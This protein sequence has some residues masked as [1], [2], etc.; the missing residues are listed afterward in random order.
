MSAVGARHFNVAPN[1]EA[2]AVDFVPGTDI[3]RA[4]I[5]GAVGSVQPCDAMFVGNLEIGDFVT[6]FADGEGAFE[7]EVDAVEG[8]NILIG[9]HPIWGTPWGQHDSQP[10]AGV[11][12]YLPVQKAADGV[13]LSSAMRIFALDNYAW[14]IRGTLGGDGLMPG[15]Q[16]PI[17]GRVI[18]TLPSDAKPPPAT[19]GFGVFLIGDSEGRQVG[20]GEDFASSFLTPTGL[21]IETGFRNFI[22][23]SILGDVPIDWG[24][25]DGHWVADF[26]ATLE[27]PDNYRGGLYELM[28]QLDIPLEVPYV[29][30]DFLHPDNCCAA[31]LGNFTIGDPAPMRVAATLLADVFSEGTRGG[32]RARE[33]AMTFDISPR[34]ATRHD[35]VVPRLDS[36]GELWTYRLEPYVPLFGTA[37]R[38]SPPVPP[39]ALDFSDSEL[40]VTIARP[41]GQTQ[42]LGP[43][44]LTRYVFLTPR[45]PGC[46]L[47]KITSGS[48]PSGMPQLQGR[49]DTFAYQFPLYG[50]YVVTLEGHIA[51]HT[52][53]LYEIGGTYDITV[54]NVLDIETAMLPG[55]PFE[56][57][58]AIA[59]TLTVMPGVPAEVSYE[60]T[61]VAADGET[62]VSVFT[63]RANENGWWDGDGDVFAFARHGEYRIDV[64]AR[65]TDGKGDLWAGRLRFGSA[66]ATPDA[67][68]IAHGRR[69]SDSF[70]V[71][72]PPWFFRRDFVPSDEGHLWPPFFTGDIQWGVTE[73]R[74]DAAISLR[75]SVQIVDND[76]PL[77][78]RA[79]ELGSFETA[80]GVTAVVTIEESVRAGS[81]ALVMRHDWDKGQGMHPEE[82]E[83]WSYMYGSAQRPGVR[84]REL[85]AGEDTEDPYWFFHD[86]YLLQSGNGQL[87]DEPGDFKFQYAAAVIRDD[88][89]GE[90][91]YAIYG[92]G[93]VLTSEDDTLGARVM[94]PFQGAAGGPSGGPLFTVHGREVDMFFLPLGVR[95]GAVLETGDVFRMAGPIMPTLPSRIGY[96]VIA[97]DGKTR[98]FD[99]RANAVGYFYDPADDFVLDQPGLWTV[100]LTV[101]HDGLTSAGPVEPP[102]PTGGPLTPDG[103]AFTF[104]VM[105]GDT[106]RLSVDTDSAQSTLDQW[107]CGGEPV[108]EAYFEAA[109]P[110][111][112]TGDTARVIV[113]MPG[114]VLVDEDAVVRA[115]KIKWDLDARAL[116]RLA[117]NFDYEG[118]TGIA[119]TITVTFFAEGTLNGQSAQAAG[120]IVTHGARV[121]LAPAAAP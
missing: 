93:W 62:T 56:V 89:S 102:F 119:D 37:E 35:P 21:P 78:V 2:I 63:G 92:S 20:R 121:P 76:H 71:V 36:Y 74:G 72:P 65:Y 46:Y 101:T 32:V 99:G 39:V 42:V 6:L 106:N 87:G 108:H 27:V 51:D 7:A 10:P 66:V 30:G 96:T 19:L 15:Q 104:V 64:E 95:P 113:T 82:V 81:L 79:W 28:A 85:I 5:T 110:G 90:G 80:S 75:N 49:G 25:E 4:H 117:S 9:R 38:I 24:L 114:T 23:N 55:T 52:G 53:R 111:G 41:D 77:V 69:G 40:T 83:L 8:T 100:D 18:L 16:V 103:A 91:V 109:L 1:T 45:T 59:P 33:D 17:S 47:G 70:Q 67:P 98:S 58:D 68:I 26:A 12:L 73:E 3:G 13:A 107:Y 29:E 22:L 48:N 11:F 60:V 86:P 14:I 97:P 88:S 57:G 61:H 116:N 105:D 94:P 84:V 34:V 120:A 31:S 115:G 112:W 50:D 43:A 118:E 54:A 44:P